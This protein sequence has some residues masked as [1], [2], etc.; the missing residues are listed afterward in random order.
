LDFEMG[1]Y[2]DYREPKRR[3]YD[4]DSIFNDYAAVGGPN[5]P[6]STSPQASVPVDA[7]VK[8][9]NPER[10]FGFVTAV[11]GSYAFLHVRQLE[12][13][14]RST[15][16]EGARI[17]VRI[18][19]GQK[20]PEVTEVLEVDATTAKATGSGERRAGRRPSSQRQSGL[21]PT[22][23]IGFV[24]WYNAAKGFGFIGQDGGGNDVFVH[25]KTLE[26]AGLSVLRERQRVRMQVGQ[27][28]KGL[29]A[30]SIEPLE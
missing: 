9:F 4:E 23:G 20:G 21:G 16:P 5:H 18:G 11:G 28:K 24:K 29:E 12:A 27:G 8:W 1:R 15:V 19:R 6:G 3:V 13:A 25:A 17:K 10:G 26:R 22:E 7:V 30:R 2:K 14:G